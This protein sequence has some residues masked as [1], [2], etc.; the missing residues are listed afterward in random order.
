[1][2]HKLWIH[3]LMSALFALVLAVS[4][5]GNLI[6]GYNLPVEAMWK[7][8]LWCAFAAVAV[9]VLFQIPHGGKIIICIAALGTLGLCLAELV[10]PFLQEQT[11]TL[12]YCISSHY[13]DVYNW[14]LLGAPSAWDVS[15]PLILWAIF[16]TVCVNWYFC[17][18][19]HFL[20]AMIPTVMPLVLCL[21]TADKSPNALYPCLMILALAILLIS[22]WTRRKQPDQSMKL[23]LWLILPI[24]LAFVLVFI[25]NPKMNYVNYAGK[26][27]KNLSVWFEDVQDVAVSVMTGTPIN[28][29]GKNRV[30]LQAVGSKNTSSRSVMLVNSPIDGK[31]YLRERDYDVYTGIAWEATKERKEKFPAGGTSVGTLTILTYTTRST[32]FVPYYAT[33]GIELVGGSL[34][35]EDDL[36]RYRYTLSKEISKKTSLPGAQYKELPAETKAWATELVTKITEEAKAN[37]EKVWK[38]QEYVRNSASYDTEAI[39][40]DSSYTDFAQWFLEERDTGYCIHYATTATVLLRAAGIPA[41]YVEGYAVNCEA[42]TDV[43]VSKND[44]HAWVEYYDMMSRAWCVLEVTPGHGNAE[45]PQVKPGAP[46]VGIQV[47][48]E[49][50]DTPEEDIPVDEIPG[51]GPP[52]HLPQWDE[53]EDPTES[54]PFAENPPVEEHPTEDTP[55]E[56]T[57]VPEGTKVP[58]DSADGTRFLNLRKWIKIVFYCLLFVLG[59]LLQGYVRILRKRKLWNRGEPNTVAIWRWRQTCSL[60]NLLGQYYPEELDDLAKKAKFSQ[61]EMQADELQKFEDYRLSLVD[62]IAEKPWYQRAF[63]K[64]IMAIDSK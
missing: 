27:Q 22:D 40:M 25:C 59:V 14:P 4:S 7:I 56:P 23:T 17:R 33:A 42:G 55:T 57:T 32:L 54:D 58:V 13:H 63:F 34:E 41:R 61:H 24:T 5:V 43:V 46:S 19:K 53:M 36:D 37:Q 21:L 64:W 6:T 12:C 60:A 44:A 49:S 3:Q 2:K 28:S 31:L 11:E 47:P 35:N 29:S 15:A 8:W 50:V 1:M 38:I 16:V 52:L 30:N 48:G 45:T 10:Q 18:R 51:D 20:V 26:I 62:V 9:A 39:R